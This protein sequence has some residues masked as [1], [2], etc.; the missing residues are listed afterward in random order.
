MAVS[1]QVSEVQIPEEVFESFFENI[2]AE[3]E[4]KIYLQKTP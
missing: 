1:F 3:Y 4:K 2:N